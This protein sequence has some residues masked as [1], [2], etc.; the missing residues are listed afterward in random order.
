M[1][2]VITRV[3]LSI[4]ML[5]GL[6]SLSLHG[7]DNFLR[8]VRHVVGGDDRQSRL[9]EHL[10]AELLV[11][12]LHAYHQGDAELHFPGGGNDAFRDGLAAHDAA[13]NVYQNALHLVVF[14]HEL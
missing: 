11:R 3:F 10:S 5:M 7:R 8:R 6:S 14:E 9:L 1:P 4:R 12:A 2:W 13:E